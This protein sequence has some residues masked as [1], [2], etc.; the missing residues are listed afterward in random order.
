MH[1]LWTIFIFVIIFYGYKGLATGLFGDKSS[2]KGGC[3]ITLLQVG[4][5]A[6]IVMSYVFFGKD[7]DYWVNII[8][9]YLGI[10]FVTWIIGVII[11][12]FG[13]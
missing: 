10:M 2:L 13:R 11:Y 1:I 9:W 8:E 12:V 7:M 4:G 6:L 3:L 5:L